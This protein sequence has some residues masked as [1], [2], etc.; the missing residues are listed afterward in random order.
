[1]KLRSKRGK[2]KKRKKEKKVIRNAV[3]KDIILY[4]V[5]SFIIYDKLGI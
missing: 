2:I 3:V 1:M 5:G 4:N